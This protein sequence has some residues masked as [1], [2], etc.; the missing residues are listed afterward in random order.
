VVRNNWVQP[1]YLDV[2]LPAG[3][4]FD[5][6]VGRDDTTFLFAVDGELAVGGRRASLPRRTLGILGEGDTVRVSS[7][8]G[9]RFLLVSAQPLREPV[10][11]GGP[12]VMNTK[13]EVVQAFDDYRHGRF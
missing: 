3:A 5:Q 13:E 12:F 11:R 4:D 1:T 10:A 6:P 9:A 8:G 2:T 7:D